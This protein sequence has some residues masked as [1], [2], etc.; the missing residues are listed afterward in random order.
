MT[1]FIR[2]LTA[3]MKL[4]EA[5]GA[6]PFPG[7]TSAKLRMAIYFQLFFRLSE[8]ASDTRFTLHNSFHQNLYRRFVRGTT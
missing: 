3:R 6:D 1:T 5:I 2:V 4:F 8:S 7:S